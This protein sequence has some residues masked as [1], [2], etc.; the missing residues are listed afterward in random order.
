MG[1]CPR[2]A[3]RLRHLADPRDH[4]AARWHRGLQGRRA[5]LIQAHPVANQPNNPAALRPYVPIGDSVRMSVAILSHVD[6]V[7]FGITADYESSPDLGVFTAGQLPG[8]MFTWTEARVWPRRLPEASPAMVSGS[9]P[10][11]QQYR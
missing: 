3:V 10:A 4:P 2:R 5:L 7:S 9:M 1:P 8:V 11:T 6:T